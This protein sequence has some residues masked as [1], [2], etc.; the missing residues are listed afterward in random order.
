MDTF[1]KRF[2]ERQQLI[3][4]FLA[5]AFA[6]NVWA[7]Y[8]ITQEIPAWILRLSLGEMMGVMAHNLY[9]ALLDSLPIFILLTIASV[10]LPAAWLKKRF[11]S[12][13]SAVA[14][15]TAVWLI[16]LHKTNLIGT[17]DTTG[18]ALWVGSYVVVTA[19]VYFV[20][21]R[22]EKAN[23][24]VAN[25]VERLAL[26]AGIYIFIDVISIIIVIVRNIGG[27]S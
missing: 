15:L 7:L 24:G 4:V 9:L 16:V 26:L 1:K 13:G 21:Q 22:N 25:F 17:R 18:L 20:I 11:V 6:S 19:V 8:N 14:V 23:K 2:P 10:I 3:Y 12:I 27:V 5:S